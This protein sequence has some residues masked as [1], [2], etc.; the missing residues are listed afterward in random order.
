[1]STEDTGKSVL[2]WAKGVIALLPLLALIWGAAPVYTDV[3]AL[4]AEVTILKRDTANELTRVSAQMGDLNVAVAKLVTKID[5]LLRA[6]EN[7]DR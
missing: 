2:N 6:K 4:K 3:Q 7:E 5:I 1:M